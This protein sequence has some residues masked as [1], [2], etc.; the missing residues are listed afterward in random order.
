M[1]E[2]YQ[3]VIRWRDLEVHVYNT[4]N[5]IDDFSHNYLIKIQS[6]TQFFYIGDCLLLLII[7]AGN[8]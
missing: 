2:K 6:S 7:M 5:T 4:P 8:D 3:G 1:I